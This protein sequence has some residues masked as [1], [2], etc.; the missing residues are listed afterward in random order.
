MASVAIIDA[1]P[2]PQTANIVCKLN[3]IKKVAVNILKPSFSSV[4]SSKSSFDLTFLYE[5]AMVIRCVNMVIAISVKDR[6]NSGAGEPITLL[7]TAYRKLVSWVLKEITR[8]SIDTTGNILFVM[9]KT[10]LF[11]EYFAP[12]AFSSFRPIPCASSC[13]ASSM[14][15]SY[16]AAI[17]FINGRMAINRTMPTATNAAIHSAGMKRIAS[18]I[19]SKAPDNPSIF[20]ITLALAP[21]L[22]TSCRAD[23]KAKILGIIMPNPT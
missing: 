6:N 23:V 3:G 12:S 22:N 18:G 5:T 17:F 4:F 7:N 2:N 8:R 13:P 20:C 14:R 11:M 16:L 15:V 1:A 21:V 10:N 9:E 19:S